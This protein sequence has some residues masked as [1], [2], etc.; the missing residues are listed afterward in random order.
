MKAYEEDYGP[1]LE[2]DIQA[3]T[4]GY[5]EQILVCLLQRSKIDLNLIKGQFKKMYGKTLSSMIMVSHEFPIFTSVCDIN[6]TERP[7]CYDLC[8]KCPP[9]SYGYHMLEL[10]TL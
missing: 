6:I 8:P 5:L 10:V 9:L 3:D 7:R 1:S 2:K 4:S